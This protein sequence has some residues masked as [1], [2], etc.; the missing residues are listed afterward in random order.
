MLEDIKSN[1]TRLI[2]FYEGEKQRAD[3]LESSL[4][5]SAAQIEQYKA[6]ITELNSRI[7]NLKLSMAFTGGGDNEVAK[8]RIE[9]LIR[10]IDKCIKMLEQ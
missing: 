10:E 7:D 4:R 8:S 3:S 2:A 5:E 6:Q 9:K 1:I